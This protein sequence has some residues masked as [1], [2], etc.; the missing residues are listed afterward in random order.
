ML[1][2]ALALSLQDTSSTIHPDTAAFADS[3]TEAV[4]QAAMV[5]H[6]ASDQEVHDYSATLRYR[7]SFGLGRRR[8]ARIAPLSVEEQAA[9]ITWQAPNDLRVDMVGRRARA[10]SPD[11]RMQSVFDKPW[12]VPRGL[13]D[14]VRIFGNDF[15][16]RAAVYPLAAG[17]DQ[18]YH[19]RL[20]DS[21]SVVTPDGRQI[22]LVGVEVEPRRTGYSLT[23]GR[24]W[25]DAASFD[26]VRFTF[27]FVG[28]N[29]WVTPDAPTRSDSSDAKRANKLISRVLS[30]DVDLEYALQDRRYWMPFRQ[31]VAGRVELPWFGTLVIPFEAVTTFDEYRINQGQPVVFAVPLPPEGVSQDSVRAFIR[32]RRDSIR[33]EARRRGRRNTDDDD[34]AREDAGRWLNG[35]YEIHR[36]PAES[37]LAYRG[38]DDSLELDTDPA[39]QLRLRDVSADLERLTAG[40]PESYTGRPTHGFLRD[41]VGELVRFNRVQG[42]TIGAGYQWSL[43][44]TGFLSLRAVGRIGTSDSR[45]TGNLTFIREAPGARWTLSGFREVR[46]D[47]PFARGNTFSNTLDA[48]FVG[49]DDADYELAQGATLTRVGS[50]GTGVELSTSLGIQD[51]RSV[52]REAHSWLNDAIG[53]TGDFPQNPPIREGAYVTL[54]AGLDGGFG[55]TRWTLAGDLTGN[56]SVQVGRL[57][58]SLSRPVGHA[59]RLP[60]LT[61]EGGI[62]TSDQLPQ[63]LFRLGGLRTVRGFDYGV[64]RGSS[65]WAAQVD[66]PLS[67]GWLRPVAF[68]DLGQAARPR[69]LFASPV[70]AGG[71]LGLSLLG[72]IL[73]FDLS[74]PF[75][76][77]GSGLRFDVSARL[78]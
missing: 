67:R 75:T 5:R 2:L 58:G 72:G 54:A 28:S 14:S 41:E 55:R 24:L 35:R 13:G 63:Q 78:F 31:S 20:V 68:A 30:L 33:A 60:V 56:E 50:L 17:A 76:D 10:R 70:R 47:D 34:L 9:R 26:V 21:V 44:S 48:I 19:Y 29:I 18:L 69:D 36:P 64:A 49:H 23:A 37:L 62:A 4:I 57:F 61:L 42:H 43:S 6:Q 73:R 66:W 32:A 51:Q 52:R 1:L 77:G 53:G 12:F 74:H 27:R 38:W 46:S 7:A 39:D 15:P 11:Y 25:L 45:F 22:R 16:G 3:A 8:W 71:G 65:F 59:V 40:L